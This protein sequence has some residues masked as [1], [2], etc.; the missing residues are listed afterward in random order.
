MYAPSHRILYLGFT[1]SPI[2]FL[3]DFNDHVTGITWRQAKGFLGTT[4]HM[5]MVSRPRLSIYIFKGYGSL[6]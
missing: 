1:D 5:S 2:S 4:S 3:L 6:R